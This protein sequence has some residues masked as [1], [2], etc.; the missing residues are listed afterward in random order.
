MTPATQQFMTWLAANKPAV[1]ANVWRLMR[2]TGTPGMHGLGDAT[3]DSSGIS[4]L[5]SLTSALTTVTATVGSVAGD[6]ALVQYNLARAKQGLAPVTALPTTPVPTASQ[7]A[8]ASVKGIF[9]SPMAI[10]GLGVAAVL[11]IV[12]VARR[13]K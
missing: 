12:L 2:A 4:F 1:Y 11:G 8:L 7:N 9:S 10:L 3:T 13:K 5:D 6:T